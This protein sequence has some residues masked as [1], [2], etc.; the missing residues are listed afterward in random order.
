[1]DSLNQICPRPCCNCEHT[2]SAGNDSL[3]T[4]RN[5]WPVRLLFYVYISCQQKE[6]LCT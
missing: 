6:G 2:L 5:Y 3:R 1:M 4:A